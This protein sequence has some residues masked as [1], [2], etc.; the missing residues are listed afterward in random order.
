MVLFINQNTL[1]SDEFQY[2]WY[3]RYHYL[4]YGFAG[5]VSTIGE[6]VSGSIV[7][8]LLGVGVDPKGGLV[9]I[10][11]SESIPDWLTT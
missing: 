9:S 3:F 4:D 11:F 1:F 2:L 8:V 10:F 7:E 5:V 6:S